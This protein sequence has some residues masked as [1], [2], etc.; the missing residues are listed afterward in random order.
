M[1]KCAISQNYKLSSHNPQ[2]MQNLQ[3]KLNTQFNL[4]LRKIK[5]VPFANSSYSPILSHATAE[6]K[7]LTSSDGTKR[8]QFREGHITV[9][10]PTKD[11]KWAVC[12]SCQIGCPIG[13]TFC[14]TP[15]LDRNLTAQEILYQVTLAQSIIGKL[16]TSVVF[17]GM[18]EPMMNF[19]NVDEATRL[20]NK[21][22]ISFKRITVSTSGFYLERLLPVPYHVALS[23]HTPFDEIRKNLMPTTKKISELVKF[24]HDYSTKRKF[25]LMIEYALMRGINDRDED[26][27]ELQKI[28]WPKNIFFNFIEYNAKGEFQKSER[29]VEFKDAMRTCGYKAFIRPSRGADISAACGML[30]FSNTTL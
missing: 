13:C 25:G 19:R 22:G 14:H 11:E 12:V 7:V 18:G 8:I 5:V 29:L 16:P 4:D 30:D 10:I 23:L 17:M 3:S 15:K 1:E 6:Y 9:L 27:A 2:S 20:I 28:N 24:A 21:L 26:L